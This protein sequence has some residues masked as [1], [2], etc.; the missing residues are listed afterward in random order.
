MRAPLSFTSPSGTSSGAPNYSNPPAFNLTNTPAPN[1]PPPDGLLLY[2][3]AATVTNGTSSATKYFPFYFDASLSQ[4]FCGAAGAARGGFTRIN[5]SWSRSA[6]GGGAIS[7][8]RRLATG[9]ASG[10]VDL[11]VSAADVSYTPSIPKFGDTVQVRFRVRND[12]TADAKGVPI[13][14]Q[15]NGVTVASD[16]FDVGAGRTALGGLQW[17]SASVPVAASTRPAALRPARIG[18]RTGSGPVNDTGGDSGGPARRPDARLR[19]AGH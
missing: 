12:G 5:G 10:S 15:V 14:L 7:L 18:A 4:N 16:T 9:A 13:A 17:N 3:F 6:V 2:F 8:G 11:H 1:V 19:A